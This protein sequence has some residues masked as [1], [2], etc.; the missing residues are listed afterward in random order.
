MTVNLSDYRT[1]GTPTL[2]IFVSLDSHTS[3][4]GVGGSVRYLR[5]VVTNEDPSRVPPLDPD[6]VL[7]CS[8]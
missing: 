2:V 5:G 4:T 6:C 7:H 3:Q 8:H 1:W